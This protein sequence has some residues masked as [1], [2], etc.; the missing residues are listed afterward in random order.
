MVDSGG[1]FCHSIISNHVI[2]YCVV[3]YARESCL[4]IMKLE[5][6]IIRSTLGG[7]GG[8]GEEL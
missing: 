4:L 7:G 5:T 2:S 6:I 8:R 3:F 1:H